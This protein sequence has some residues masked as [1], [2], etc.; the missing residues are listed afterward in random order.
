MPISSSNH[1][2]ETWIF[3]SH[4]SKLKKKSKL[5]VK[6]LRILESTRKDEFV[7]DQ[8]FN[9]RVQY[10]KFKLIHLQWQ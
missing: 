5:L 4:A 6:Q 7:F 1:K 2:V 3:T 9:W 10:E 8:Y